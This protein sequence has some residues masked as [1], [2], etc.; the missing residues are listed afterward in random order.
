[1]NYRSALFFAACLAVFMTATA[2]HAGS[3][4]VK[5]ATV[6]F[7]NPEG[8]LRCT[9][10][11]KYAYI[12]ESVLEVDTPEFPTKYVFLSKEDA[13]AID[14]DEKRP[15][16]AI[17]IMAYTE[18]LSWLEFHAYKLEVERVFNLEK[19]YASEPGEKSLGIFNNDNATVSILAWKKS[20]D[21]NGIYFSTHMLRKDRLILVHQYENFTTL[22]RAQAFKDEASARLRAMH[23]PDP[24][25]DG[26]ITGKTLSAAV[27]IALL[28]VSAFFIYGLYRFRP[29][30]K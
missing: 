16:K 3:I 1:M 10:D 30:K 29:K 6:S 18:K 7:T 2:A 25:P 12:L 19:E 9:K 5:G 8:Y 4:T 20:D 14:A 23:F 11:G 21:Y 27:A 26:P 22:E 13:D 15:G 24:E 17:V 28:L